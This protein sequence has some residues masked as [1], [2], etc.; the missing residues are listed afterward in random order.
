MPI[1][2]GLLLTKLHLNSTYENEH[3]LNELVKWCKENISQDIHYAGEFSEKYEDYC[4]LA[5][6][7]LEDFLPYIPTNL[8]DSV[9]QFG[10]LN[11]LQYAVKCGYHWFIKE[12]TI[13]FQLVNL[14]NTNMMTP[15]H[16]S[17]VLGYIHTTEALLA[18]GA[19]SQIKN[20]LNQF[21][22]YQALFLP[23]KYDGFLVDSKKIIFHVLAKKT[24][25]LWL[26]QDKSG[27]SVLHLM[28]THDAFE[29]LANAFL[30]QASALVVT[31]N[32]ASHYPIHTAILNNQYKMTDLLLRI[33]GVS[34]LEDSKRRRALHYAARC[35]RVEI[36]KLCINATSEI[37]KRDSSFKTPLLLAAEIGNKHAVEYLLSQE[38]D[39]RAT[40]LDGFSI[41][42]HA[43]NRQNT[44]LTRWLLSTIPQ[45]LVNLVDKVGH[46]PLFYARAHH[47]EIVETMLVEAGAEA[48]ASR[49][50]SG[51]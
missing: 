45:D 8:A 6:R 27:D 40:D 21:P 1:T 35:G 37:D 4:S 2:L 31:K 29:E 46:T 30:P 28:A 26:A 12:Q 43:V 39:V 42:H 11:T 7:F 16:T 20:G 24:P 23:I 41:L 9:P 19:D 5:K 44:N 13:S 15:L 47:N 34:N 10:E 49:S 3:Q 17:A 18:K 48:Y 38:A 14:P 50:Q 22:A 36:I 32:K 51:L 25:Q 33:P